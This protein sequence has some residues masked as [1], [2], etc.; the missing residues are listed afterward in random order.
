MDDDDDDD[1][2]IMPTLKKKRKVSAAGDLLDD[3]AAVDPLDDL[4]D[5]YDD[6]DVIAESEVC[7]CLTF[8]NHSPIVIY[9][10]LTK[11][12]LRDFQG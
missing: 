2:D 10:M 6:K 9:G 12:Y 1:D 4:A 5:V 11:I 7:T 8:F 3:H